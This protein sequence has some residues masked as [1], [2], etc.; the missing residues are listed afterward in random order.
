MDVTLGLTALNVP[1]LAQF[2]VLGAGMIDILMLFF[3][4]AVILLGATVFPNG[5]EW[6]EK[7]M[8]LSDGAVGSIFAAIL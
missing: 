2:F 8:S 7:K 3:A 5:L 1:C 6:F 4:L